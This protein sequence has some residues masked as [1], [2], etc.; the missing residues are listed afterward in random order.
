MTM[1]ELNLGSLADGGGDDQITVPSGPTPGAGRLGTSLVLSLHGSIFSPKQHFP[2]LHYPIR[3]L[4]R[5][6]SLI[7]T[8]DP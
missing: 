8:L 1:K 6:I 3:W 2:L 7:H 4:L 5:E